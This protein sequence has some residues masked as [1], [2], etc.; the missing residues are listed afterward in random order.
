MLLV[1]IPL[2]AFRVAMVAA[3]AASCPVLT[4]VV[5]RIVPVVKPVVTAKLP[6]VPPTA[7]NCPVD[8]LVVASIVPVVRPVLRESVP[9]LIVVVNKF[10]IVPL[11]VLIPDSKF[12]NPV[13]LSTIIGLPK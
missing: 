10:A 4:L 2:G 7:N 3:V 12:V 13:N 1:V 9:E 11:F 6:K 5:A 8:M